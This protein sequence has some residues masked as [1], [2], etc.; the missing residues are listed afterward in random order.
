MADVEGRRP[1]L[2][3][4]RSKREVNKLLI[5]KGRRRGSIREILDLARSQGIVVQKVDRAVLDRLSVTSNH[6]GVI[7]QVAAIK[8]KKI[9]EVL[10][11]EEDPH[12]PP[13]LVLLD[14]IQDPHNLG[15]IL[16]SS[17]AVG[18]NAVVIPERRAAGV[19]AAVMKSSA[20][21]ANH[22]PVCR[23]GNMA[24]TIDLLKEKGFWIAGADPRGELCY[25]QD[26]GGPL[27]LVIGGEGDG[28]G[29]LVREKCDFLSALPMRGRLNSLN[30]AVAGAV[31]MFEVLRQRQLGE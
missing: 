9:E 17:E 25:K 14:G 5:A 19:T 16:R 24:D 6:Q 8:Y 21:A 20:G 28:L 2:E 7:A 12:W 15:S 31:I 29:R 27:A 23:V 13:F 18:V 1:V 11:K 4:L 22:V 26:L 10:E 30:A 3:L